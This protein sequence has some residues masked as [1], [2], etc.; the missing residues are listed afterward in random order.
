MHTSSK[1][2]STGLT[3]LQNF[4]VSRASTALEERRNSDVFDEL[5]MNDWNRIHQA[6]L[7]EIKQTNPSAHQ[8]LNERISSSAS[9]SKV[10]AT[11]V[12]SLV[13]FLRASAQS[14]R[15]LV[16]PSEIVDTMWRGVIKHEPV[17]YREFC[18]KFMGKEIHRSEHNSFAASSKKPGFGDRLC[19]TWVALYRN[20]G[21]LPSDSCAPPLFATDANC[22]MPGGRAFS[23][24]DG[25]VFHTDLDTKGKSNKIRSYHPDITLERMNEMKLLSDAELAS[26]SKVRALENSRFNRI[27]TLLGAPDNLAKEKLYINKSSRHVYR[28]PSEQ[29]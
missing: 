17:L 25:Q 18:E 21:V 16:M 5:S 4:S 29:A 24:V 10:A 19:E 15:P 20:A 7:T 28:L 13:D 11:A 3:P 26:G 12:D 27:M 2:T 8:F 6:Y 9:S 14:D 23:S 1:T 22:R